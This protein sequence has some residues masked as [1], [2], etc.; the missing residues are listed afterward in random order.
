MR[1]SFG[2]KVRLN[3]A[4]SCGARGLK[5]RPLA[6]RPHFRYGERCTGR[7]KTGGKSCYPWTKDGG[8][9]TSRLPAENAEGLDA[10]L[11]GCQKNVVLNCS[12]R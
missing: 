12:W 9:V 3:L 7:T 4:G 5:R 6:P 8:Q 1:A 2:V 10:K 11:A